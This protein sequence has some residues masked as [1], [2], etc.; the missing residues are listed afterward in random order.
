RCRGCRRRQSRIARAA[1]PLRSASRASSQGQ[2]ELLHLPHDAGAP[3][4]R[5]RRRGVP[6]REARGHGA[7]D[8]GRGVSGARQRA[9][10]PVRDLHGGHRRRPGGRKD[11]R[12]RRGPGGGEEHARA[13]VGGWQACG[14]QG[15]L[16]A[17]PPRGR[18][19][20]PR[21]ASP[22]PRHRERGVGA[23]PPRHRAPRARWVQPVRVGPGG[24]ER[25]GGPRA[26]GR[27]AADGDQ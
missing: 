10:E 23:A 7:D 18:G 5:D 4:R 3:A 12:P 25:A 6:L 1:E 13:A 17:D 24:G 21:V 22:R 11:L 19:L 20:R 9:R 16:R 26:R 8:Q 27:G 2:S 15:A 14:L